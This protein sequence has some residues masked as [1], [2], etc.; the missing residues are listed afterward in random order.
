MRASALLATLVLG[1]IASP[2]PSAA[3]LPFFGPRPD[4]GKLP[5]CT[6]AYRESLDHRLTALEKLRAVGPEF[7]GRICAIIEGGSALLGDELPEGVRQQLKTVLGVDVDLRLIKAQCRVGQGNLDREMMT[8]IGYL[9]AE[10][11]RCTDTI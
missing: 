6:K 10:L 1:L 3:E 11:T 5:Q 8:E 2:G 9:K 7:V 4:F